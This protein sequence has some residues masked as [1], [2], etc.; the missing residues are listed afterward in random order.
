MLIGVA[1][2][3]RHKYKQFFAICNFATIIISENL[4]YEVL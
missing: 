4:V 3:Y 1:L 2:E